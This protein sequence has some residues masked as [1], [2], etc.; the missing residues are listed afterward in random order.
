LIVKI[1]VLLFGL[2]VGVPALGEERLF[3]KDLRPAPEKRCFCSEAVERQIAGLK[4]KLTAVDPKLYWMFANCFPNTLDT[5]VRYRREGGDD[6]FVITGDIDAMWLRDSAAQVW[7]YLGYAGKDE[8]LRRLIRGV[9]RRQ[10]ACILI[11]PYANAFNDGP[12][13]G[14]WQSDETE[15]KPEI[16]ERKYEIDSLCYPVRLAYAYWKKTGDGTI[17]DEKWLKVVRSILVVFK[18]QQNR[19]GFRSGYH[20]RRHTAAYHDSVHEFPIIY[21]DYYFTEAIL[22]LAGQTDILW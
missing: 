21:G 2:L 6:T 1:G 12:K 10:F 16:H 8:P 7:P 18:D 14:P 20:F 17:F 3:E 9:I 13:G 11:D 15:M 19:S 5:T 22:R 4:D